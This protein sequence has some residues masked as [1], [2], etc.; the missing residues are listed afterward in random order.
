[1]VRRLEGLPLALALAAGRA[2][3]LSPQQILDRLG[4]R[5]AL[6]ESRSAA[7]PERHRTLRAALEWSTDLL[8]E[9]LRLAFARLSVFRGDFTLEAAEAVTGDPLALDVLSELRECSLLLGS[10][11]GDGR[12]FRFLETIRELAE[13]RLDPA[14][15]A[16]LERRHAT[17]FA[18]LAAE[19]EPRLHGPE[20][21]AW[22]KK[23]ALDYPNMRAVLERGARA[24][25]L[26]PVALGL[27]RA[28][29]SFWF[30]SGPT[31]DVGALLPPLLAASSERTPDRAAALWALALYR[32]RY[33]RVEAALPALEESLAIW[34]EVG[35][36]PMATGV[37]FTLAET[38]SRA[39]EDAAAR[40]R[41]EEGL[42]LARASGDVR[43]LGWGLGA[44]A[45]HLF[46]QD[47]LDRARSLVE[48]SIAI[49]EPI[50][51]PQHALEE[52]RLA[53]IL[54]ALGDRARAEALAARSLETLRRLDFGNGVAQ[55]QALLGRG[56]AA[57]GDA[58]A[59]RA[60]LL[61]ALAGFRRGDR[62]DYL[63]QTLLD[64]ASLAIATRDVTAAR[65]RL[66]ECARLVRDRCEHL[67][68]H[69][70]LVL[71]GDLARATGDVARARSSYRACLFDLE[72]RRGWSRA[73]SRSAALAGLATLTPE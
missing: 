47:E 65:E 38:L 13:E 59:A 66:D 42:A 28:L 62:P 36:A 19:A 37:V 60:L 57:A 15:R 48:E 14:D 25:S 8:P 64:L 26:A 24:P 51:V 29:R 21:S 44:F 10:E 53:Q 72:T 7:V 30:G 11:G 55:C 73:A 33:E 43:R 52:W 22:F 69:R 41:F 71:E 70:I 56:R 39:G 67:F 2:H 49:H 12:R 17:H 5:F 6:L 32:A 35:N 16:E 61:D 50:D 3:V 68:R 40:A 54:Q 1:L 18:A 31:R 46:F 9:P 34:R 58:A 45:Q 4:P 20:G 27:A 23:L 63:A